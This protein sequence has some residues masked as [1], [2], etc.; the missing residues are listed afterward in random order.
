M[1]I[2]MLE[3]YQWHVISPSRMRM[4]EW[5]VWVIAIEGRG[6]CAYH[7]GPKEGMRVHAS[8]SEAVRIAVAAVEAAIKVVT[9]RHS[10]GR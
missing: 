1:L 4:V 3:G 10:N 6:W 8:R 2:R 7:K 9:E 5:P